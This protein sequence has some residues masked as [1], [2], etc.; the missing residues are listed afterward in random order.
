M[1]RKLLKLLFSRMVIVGLLLILQLGVI[2]WMLVQASTLSFFAAWGLT[3]VSFLVMLYI[4]G[5]PGN[6]S[7]KLAWVI[8]ILLF[9]VLGGLLYLL[10]TFQ[11]STR[12]FQ[13][14]LDTSIAKSQPLLLQDPSVL[15]QLTH[16]DPDGGSRARYLERQ[17][18]PL[19]KNT[20]AVYL[21]PGEEKFHALI[22]ALK[23]AKQF[24]FLEYFIIQ[25]GKMWD[26]IL[27][28][29]V[30]KA[31]QGVDVRVM[32]DA[33]GC[34]LLLPEHY[35]RYLESLGIR[36]QIFN[37]FRPVLSA[38]Q[39]NRDHRKIAVIDGHTAFTGGIN[40]ADEYINA[41]EK[42]G[43]WKDASVQIQGDAVW[44]FTVLFLQ[45]WRMYR[46]ESNWDDRRFL[47]HSSRKAAFAGD[48]FVQ[49]Y[50][51][52]PL[53]NQPVAESVYLDI[54]H[55]AKRYVYIN[56]PYLIIDQQ[57]LTALTLAAKS[58]VDV[59]IVTPHR[60]DK[61]LV[62]M[63]TR[64][65]YAQLIRAGVRIYEFTP[66][67]LHSKTMIS[68]D[69]AAAIG[70]VN[71]D[72]RSLYLH[73]ECGVCLYHNAAVMQIKQDFLRTLE[74]CQEITLT[75]CSRQPLAVRLL[76]KILPLFAPLM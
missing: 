59:R 35:D 48:G 33:M 47:P 55:R 23:G 66:G 13:K 24:I 32:Y 76:Q 20:T 51:D 56:T 65:Y 30:E 73:F 53:D 10:I 14:A 39:N 37:Q 46:P 72:Y 40:L 61:W 19:Y 18:F 43:Y 70:S 64:S 38:V 16:I 1:V 4:V 41:I 3:A 9:P 22:A 52:S 27:E 28:I 15:Q 17:G 60:W 36:C 11:S 42:H 63:T 45:M 5:K 75:F 12:Q 2:V 68:D 44:S 34:L 49:P 58:G 21:S 71:L 25:Q 29:L 50:G 57:M 8:P 69:T 31:G 67:F 7:Y 6:P 62:H 54:I 26:T 74:Q